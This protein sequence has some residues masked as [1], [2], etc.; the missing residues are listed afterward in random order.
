MPLLLIHAAVLLALAR[1][2]SSGAAA[3]VPPVPAAAPAV[4]CYWYPRQC[5][6]PGMA[7]TDRNISDLPPGTCTYLDLGNLCLFNVTANG[8]LNHDG[9][10]GGCASAAAEVAADVLA[11]K[12]QQPG[13][14]AYYEL[15]DVT[16]AYGD[17]PSGH[18]FVKVFSNDTLRERYVQD[19]AAWVGANRGAVDGFNVDWELTLDGSAQ[20][21]AARKGLTLFLQRLKEETGLGVSFDIGALSGF[22]NIAEVAKIQPYVDHLEFMSYFT[23]LTAPLNTAV[24][25]T[26]AD[27]GSV[28]DNIQ[29]LLAPPLNY[30]ADQIIIGVGLSSDSVM[31]VSLVGEDNAS[32]CAYWGWGCVRPDDG[33]KDEPPTAGGPH[34]TN[35]GT[36]AI[37]TPG[38]RTWDQIKADV[39]AGKGQ[40]G[41][42]GAETGSNWWYFFPNSDNVRCSRLLLP[43]RNLL[44][45]SSCVAQATWGELTWWNDVSDFDYFTDF[46]KEHKLGGVFS[47]IATSDAPDWR[48]HKQL[49]K[50]LRG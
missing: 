2:S 50:A 30:R 17:D 36:D 43:A 46:V 24:H 38:R 28:L 35:G 3:G 48:V 5:V 19:L 41:Q 13:L 37:G 47:W 18:L 49:N 32:S 31:N 42:G 26:P 27:G 8:T 33:V 7:L 16:P 11:A 15:W 14:A 1:P 4:G 22:K 23:N 25:K 34:A 12:K 20:D 45:E 9:Q 29:E 44:A 21:D 10:G 39:E 6:E 40:R